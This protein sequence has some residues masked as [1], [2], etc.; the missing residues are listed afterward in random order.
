MIVSGSSILF[1]RLHGDG[2]LCLVNVQCATSGNQFHQSRAEAVVALIQRKR[3]TSL[4]GLGLADGKAKHPDNIPNRFRVA[5]VLG[6]GLRQN[7]GDYD[8]GGG[9]CSLNSTR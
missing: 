6:L 9:S 4:C 7:S 5:D 8:V 1:G 2:G 3:Q